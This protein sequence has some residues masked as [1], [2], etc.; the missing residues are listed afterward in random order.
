M[1]ITCCPDIGYVITTLSKF[2]LEPSVFHYK[3]LLGVTK[4]LRSSITWGIRFNWPS[5]LNLD[6]LFKSIP[7]PELTNSDDISLLT[8]TACCFK[9]LLMLLLEI[10]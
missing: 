1:Y 2:S 4:Y 3:L 7:Y 10:N 5:P 8:S 6:K 9:S